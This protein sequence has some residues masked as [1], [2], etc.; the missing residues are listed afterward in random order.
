MPQ[1]TN[2]KALRLQIIE[3]FDLEELELLCDDI[4]DIDVHFGNLSGTKIEPKA[5]NLIKHMQK[6]GKMHVLLQELQSRRPHIDWESL[7]PVEDEKP[8]QA[9]QPK[10]PEKAQQVETP[11][12]RIMHMP[13]S[14]GDLP[15]S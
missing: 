3:S 2:S 13:I 10:Q 1:A 5:Q 8:G 9:E 7:Y 15:T 12:I 14:I 11:Q 4:E 6:H